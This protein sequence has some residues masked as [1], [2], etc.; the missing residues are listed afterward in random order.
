MFV[1]RPLVQVLPQLAGPVS[2]AR[3]GRFPTRVQP[4]SE[5]LPD[6]ADRAGA[7]HAFVKRDDLSADEYGGNKV[8]T[9]E[10]LLGGVLR[11]EHS[12]V[13]A[14]GGYGSNHSVATLLHAPKLG[15]R[16]GSMLWPQPVSRSALENL[17]LS[18]TLSTPFVPLPHWSALPFAIWH[19]SRVERGR[20]SIMPPG[21]A[22]PLGALGYISAALELA[23]Q[24]QSGELPCPQT[25]VVAIGSTC[26]TAGLLVG[27]RL[28]RK[29]GIAFADGLPELRAVRVTPWPVTSPVL[30]ANLA[31]RAA[32]L[33][34]R[35]SGKAEYAFSYPELKAGL[36]VDGRYLGPGYGESTK[37]G[38]RAI[39]SFA[40]SD[41][42]LDTTYSAKSAAALLQLVRD[43]SGSATAPG[44]VLYWATKSSA[45]LPAP[46]DERLASLPP[47]IARWMDRARREPDYSAL[48]AS[49]A[50][51]SRS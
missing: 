4:L 9:L 33:L 1:E 37:E 43:G 2:F 40:E 46:N 48:A 20:A 34:A 44:T 19:R 50:G 26:T 29:L 13:Y 39:Q 21:G 27:L 47:S 22:T 36:V 25:I 11:K 41:C 16:V 38:I 32:M 7:G 12:R 24:V 15:L 23:E 42:C 51:T 3:L 28:A 18:A 30:V 31:R 17:E 49:S 10:V 8:R 5:M 45:P 14:T 6:L 35:L